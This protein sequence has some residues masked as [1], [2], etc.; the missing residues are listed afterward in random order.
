MMLKSTIKNRIK[1]HEKIYRHTEKG[2]EKFTS[3]AT[4]ILGNSVTFIIAVCMVIFWFSNERFYT[5]GIHA[6]IGDVIFATTFLSLFIIQRSFVH[7]SAS[8]HLKVNELVSS[9]EPANNS[10]MNAER[11]TDE[12]IIELSKEYEELVDTIKKEDEIS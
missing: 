2:F 8:L 1:R 7:F 10:V 9:H 6:C 11:K 4:A 12:E 5:Q 3:V